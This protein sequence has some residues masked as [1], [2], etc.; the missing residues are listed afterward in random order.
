MVVSV[1]ILYVVVQTVESYFIT[2]LIQER[3]VS[4]PPGYLVMAQVLGGVLFGIIGILLAAPVG[5]AIAVMIQMLY[6]EDVLGVRPHLMG[7]E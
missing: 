2:P 5:V 6:V 4:L 3:A 7:E 1:A